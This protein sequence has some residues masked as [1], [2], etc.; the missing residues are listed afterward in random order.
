MYFLN[1]TT[2]LSFLRQN[3]ILVVLIVKNRIICT[4]LIKKRDVIFDI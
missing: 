1:H 3:L 4:K 2:K